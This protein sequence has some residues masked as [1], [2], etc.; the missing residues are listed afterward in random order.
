MSTSRRALLLA[1]LPTLWATA[2]CRPEPTGAQRRLAATVQPADAAV[3]I[4]RRWLRAHRPRSADALEAAI[5]EALG[6]E[7][8]QARVADDFRSGRVDEVDGWRLARTTCWLCALAAL[9]ADPARTR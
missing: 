9:S 8:L 2:S 1:T 4:G 6:D 7:T 3:M 5:R